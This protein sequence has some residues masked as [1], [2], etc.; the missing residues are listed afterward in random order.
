MSNKTFGAGLYGKGEN[1]NGQTS[2][3]AEETMRNS[4]ALPRQDSKWNRQADGQRWNGS[5]EHQFKRNQPFPPAK[6][7]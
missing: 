6:N 7:R 3:T 4:E 1:P 5:D 2:L